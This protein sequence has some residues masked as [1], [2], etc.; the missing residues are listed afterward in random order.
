MVVSGIYITSINNFRKAPV[1]EP[2]KKGLASKL[3]SKGTQ[4]SRE[5]AEARKASEKNKKK[6]KKKK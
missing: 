4:A 1:P 6:G 2:E 3:R 5:V